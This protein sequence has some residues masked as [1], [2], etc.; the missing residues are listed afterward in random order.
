MDDG[1]DTQRTRRLTTRG[2]A[3]R[4]RILQTAAEL[5]RTKGVAATT[6]DDVR[7]AS[8]TSKSQL[9]HYFTDKDDLVHEVIAFRARQVLEREQ[10]QLERLSS[11][12]GLER[13]RDAL[14]GSNAS[15]HGAY[16]CAIGSLANELA[17][18]D[19]DARTALEAVFRT[20]EALLANGLDRMRENGV[21]QA[22]ADPMKL[23]TGII[24]ALQGGYL[25]AQAAHDSTPM[26]IALDMAL[27]HV[28]SYA[29]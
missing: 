4:A 1:D 3:T 7:A 12:R 6:F 25:L 18:H 11:L 5:I 15:V 19:E 14:V 13:W 16:G 10:Q 22:D 28:R 23:A 27:D 20:W 9:Y 24:A 2:A 26:A 21:L 8:G 17:D 29:I